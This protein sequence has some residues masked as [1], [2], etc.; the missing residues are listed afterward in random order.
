MLI[1]SLLRG[2]DIWCIHYQGNQHYDK[3]FL[4]QTECMRAASF[5]RD[6]DRQRF[7]CYHHHLRCILAQYLKYAPSD[8]QFESNE[9]GKPSL[10]LTSEVSQEQPRLYFNLSHSHNLALCA[11]S[12]LG[13]I[14]VDLEYTASEKVID[15]EGLVKR[16]FLPSEQ[17]KFKYFTDK[18]VYHRAFFR[19]WTR[20]EA[21]L[22]ALGTGITQDLQAYCLPVSAEM[23]LNMR[24]SDSLGRPLDGYQLFDIS[25]SDHLS[26]DYVAA[27]VLESSPESSNPLVINMMHKGLLAST[28]P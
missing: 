20:K 4:D 27:C 16:F 21:L 2:V 14:G 15:L 12:C 25:L 5:L 23:S 19:S 18:Q 11:V 7:I 3:G 1:Q 10:V 26:Q 24:I 6:G 17:I 28:P 13:E 22:K 8:L 9:H